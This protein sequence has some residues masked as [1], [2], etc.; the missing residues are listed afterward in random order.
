[1]G[2]INVLEKSTAELIAAGEVVERPSSVIKELTENSIDAGAT[3]ITV[4][5]K[6]GGVK[7]MRITDNGSGI[8][9]EDVPLAFVRHATSKV[10]E[11]TD[12]DA[13][14]TLGFRGEALASVCAVA[15]V[16][17]T[18]CADCETMGTV[19]NISGDLSGVI[20]DAGCPK[21][22]TIIVRDLFY[23]I[24][25]RMKFLKKDVSEGNAVA[26]VMDKIALSHPEIAF[27]FIRD[28]KQT[29][30]T[31]GDGKL[32]SAIYS[33]YGKEFAGGLIPVD[34]SL[35]NVKITGYISK[36]Q[37]CRPNRNMQNFFI[38]GRFVKCRTAMA[39][40]EQACKGSVMV[41]KFPSCVL[42]IQI[43]CGAVDVNVHPAKIEVR[44]INERPVFDAVYH[45]V[46]TALLCG[47]TTK[48]ISIEPKMPCG[49]SSVSG[50]PFTMQSLPY[51]A[52]PK[53][54]EQLTPPA[55]KF[56]EEQE[57]QIFIPKHESP[58]TSVQVADIENSPVQS[59]KFKVKNADIFSEPKKEE[60]PRE[61]TIQ[62]KITEEIPFDSLKSKETDNTSSVIQAENSALNTNQ[63]LQPFQNETAEKNDN[64]QSIRYI[65]E[66]FDTYILV[67]RGNKELVMIDKHAAHERI[68]YEQIKKEHGKGCMQYLLV[69]MAISLTKAEYTA[70]T[71]NLNVM[72]QSGFEIEDFGNGTVMVRGVPQ[73]IDHKDTKSI[74][75]EIAGYLCDH[76]V[77]INTEEMDWIYHSM[78]CRAAI[79]AGNINHKEELMNIVN[80]LAN[81][82]T[83]RYCPHG[84]PVSVI[85]TKKEIEKNFG[86][87]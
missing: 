21:G 2:R 22:T 75:I 4:E 82:D 48:Q 59:D 11:Q 85:L 28:G 17:L 51:A 81:D 46:K 26:G 29:L 1:M 49:V 36:P 65:G 19:F 71:D 55:H 72:E 9:R 45:A 63:V 52:P 42:N 84:R 73:Y 35:N 68:L 14:S 79:K 5:I 43:A 86:R 47:D 34:Y 87:I 7:Y 41:G 57:P 53:P 20:D 69:P 37:S 15:K 77:D 16:E 74:V 10:K 23:N 78:A 66:V 18:T 31:P 67:Q 39:A 60:Q 44:F 64:V 13:I 56:E 24:P 62:E 83:L 54:K 8:L 76:K 30:K 12:L 27:T 40:L 50:K 38:N 58:V 6:N 32:L 3:N 33:V 61:N 25:A 70:I 80:K